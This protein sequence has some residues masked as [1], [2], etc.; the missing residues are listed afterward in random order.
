MRAR[1]DRVLVDEYQDTNALQAGILAGLSPDGR[2]LTVVGDDAQSIYAFR[3]ATVRNILDFPQHF[4][5]ATV[6]TLTQ[7]YRSHQ[8]LLS[9]TNP[10]I[11]QAAER[12]E[13]HLWS[14]R[15]EGAPPSLVT[16]T[17]E[18]E[19]T[20]YVVER[21]LEH[22]EAGVQLRQQAVLFRASHHSLDLE[23]ELSRRNIPYHKYG[24]LK[25][26]EAAHVKDLLAFLRFAENPRDVTAG[27]RM[28]QLLPGI[29]PKRAAEL[30][31]DVTR[32]GGDAAGAWAQAAVPPA[33]SQTWPRL[34]EMLRILTAAEP[35]PVP[36]QLHLVRTFYAPL[37][38]RTHDNPGRPHAGPRAARAARDPLPRPGHVPGRAHAR[39]TQLDRRS[40]RPTGARRGL[41]D[42]EHHA[43]RQGAGVGRRVRH[44]RRRRQHPVG[45]VDR[46]RRRDR[47]GAAAV[48]RRPDQSKGLALCHGAAAVLQ[49][50]PGPVRP[51]RVRPAHTVRPDD[52]KPFF[53][54]TSAGPD[55]PNGDDDGPTSGRHSAGPT[56]AERIRA[57][58]MSLWD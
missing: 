12:Y 28:L 8:P 15:A 50:P 4:P 51:V 56:T 11:A 7:N 45:H 26:L 44:P 17:D 49:A 14:R 1:F 29:G 21:I 5:G 3:A 42:P 33:L 54:H 46:Q 22:R 32:A 27:A 48:L 6:V 53:A 20:E 37:L 31:D 39:P 25:F 18:D 55:L 35:P 52:V 58:L 19:Q 30:L 47:R 9:A 36:A 13:K 41:P 43:L 34:V 16:C 38:E 10:V 24:G 40:C 57:G 23:L 2:G